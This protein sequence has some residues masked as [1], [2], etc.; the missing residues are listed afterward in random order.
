MANNGTYGISKPA[1]VTS[2]DVDIFYHF[3]PSRST[4]DPQFL[5]FRRLESRYLEPQTYTDGGQTGLNLNG[6]YNLKLPL[7][8]FSEAG[9]Y[10]IYIKPKE[11][12]A[13]ILDVST[14]AA[15]PNVRG[16][17]IDTSQITTSDTTIFNNGGLVGYRVE[18]GSNAGTTAELYR[19]ITSSNRCEPVAQNLNDPRAKGIRYA[20]N[21][22][23]NLLFCTVTPSAAMSFNSNSIPYIGTAQETIRLV[24]TKFNPVCLE[25]E[26]T[27]HDIEDVSTMLEGAQLRNLDNALI[28][29]FNK[30][31]DIYY[32]AEYGHSVDTSNGIHSDWK[33]PKG[34]NEI[35]NEEKD[36]MER[37]EESL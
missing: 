12:Q 3:R 30:D 18:Y 15:Y 23:S 14:L 28:T 25:I 9:I 8:R 22:A 20:F 35:I 33:T 29:T 6:M 7:D 10:T 13:T 2:A 24:S 16:I 21:D 31:G 5:E 26:M 4:D 1:Q 32:Q 34:N 19:I 27:E 36:R 37:I 17:V 11:I